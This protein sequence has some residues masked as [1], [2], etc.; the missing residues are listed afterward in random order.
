M[1]YILNCISGSTEHRIE[2]DSL[3]ELDGYA[4]RLG[5][6]YVASYVNGRDIAFQYFEPNFEEMT[7][8]ER[9]RYSLQV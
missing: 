3:D 4:D 9:E 8:V 2:F 5:L 6:R 7:D 1:S